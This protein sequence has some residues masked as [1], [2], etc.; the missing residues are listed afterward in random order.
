MTINGSLNAKS[1]Y[2]KLDYHSELALLVAATTLSATSAK[3]QD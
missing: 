1:G 2:D 3:S